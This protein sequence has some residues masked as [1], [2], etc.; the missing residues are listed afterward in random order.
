MTAQPL[1]SPQR[2]APLRWAAI[3]LLLVGVFGWL[4]AQDRSPLD[5]VDQWGKSG[6]DW[7]DG[8]PLLI[9]ALR[10]IEIAFAT[11]GM[12]IWTS[13]AAGLLL[14]DRRFRAAAFVITV[15]VVTSLTTTVLKLQFGRRRPD[16]Q[17]Q[18]DL[19]TTKSFPSGHASSSAALAAV[20]IVLVWM[21]VRSQALRRTATVALVLMWVVVCLDRVLLGRHFPTDVVA[22]SLL[23]VA[24]TLIGIAVFDPLS[25]KRTPD[26]MTAGTTSR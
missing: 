20:L 6:E 4:V 5:S 7:A 23:G 15:M 3:C 9:D 16:W 26:R 8:H 17:D 2:A 18:I 10:L 1:I 24:V 14:L 19:L 25:E 12:I 21:L 13:I 11:I 22:G